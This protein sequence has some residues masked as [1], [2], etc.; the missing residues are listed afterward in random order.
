MSTVCEQA[1]HAW[2]LIIDGAA[3]VKEVLGRHPL[4][5]RSALQFHRRNASWLGTEQRPSRF[6]LVVA[7][8]S[9]SKSGRS[10]CPSFESRPQGLSSEGS[11]PVWLPDSTIPIMEG[12]D[13]IS[14]ERYE[15]LLPVKFS[16][17]FLSCRLVLVLPDPGRLA[18]SIFDR[19]GNILCQ[20]PLP[21]K[22]LRFPFC[23]SFQPPLPLSRTPG[24]R[25]HAV[26]FAPAFLGVDGSGKIRFA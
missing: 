21:G 25:A 26:P 24:S 8:N 10:S 3:C 13:A 5:R 1:F 23:F 12:D 14:Q 16:R 2:L 11:L 4:A 7:Q 18:V 17:P 9:S 15:F 19:L 20:P 6:F 22:R